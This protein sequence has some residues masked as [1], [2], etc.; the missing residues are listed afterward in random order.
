MA[1]Q[2]AFTAPRKKQFLKVLSETGN[3]SEAARAIGLTRLQVTRHYESNERF[4]EQWRAA[5]EEATDG[6]EREARRRAFEGTEEPVFYQGKECARV[7]R[8]SDTLM[9]ALLKAERPEKYKDRVASELSGELRG[10]VL[11]VPQIL[12]PAAWAEITAEYQRRLASGG[13][14]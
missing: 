5:L 1:R 3:V 4:A 13:G 8:Y 11:A 7:R 2:R 9:L 6:L 12:D 10:G 14:R